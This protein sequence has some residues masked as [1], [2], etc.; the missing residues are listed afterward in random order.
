MISGVAGVKYFS[1]DVKH[2][3]F[4]SCHQ[5]Q[6]VGWSL[7]QDLIFQATNVVFHGAHHQGFSWDTWVSFPPLSGYDCYYSHCICRV[8]DPN[9]ASQ[10]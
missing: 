8:P 4:P 5:C 10:A 9:G 7:G 6:P 2:F 3:S 1:W